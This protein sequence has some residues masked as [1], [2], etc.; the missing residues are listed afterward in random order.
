MSRLIRPKE[1]KDFKPI[2][3]GSY[4]AICYMIV[5]CGIISQSYKENPKMED[6]M[7]FYWEILNDDLRI[8]VGGQ[9]KRSMVYQD[10]TKSVYENSNMYKHMKP[11]LG[12][13]LLDESTGAFDPFVLIGSACILNVVENTSKKTGK[14][15]NKVASILALPK[16]IDPG[17]PENPLVLYEVGESPEEALELLPERMRKIIRDG[18]TGDDTAAN[19]VAVSFDPATGEV[20]ATPD[21]PAAPATPSAPTG[22]PAQAAQA[23]P[24]APTAAPTAAKPAE[25]EDDL[26]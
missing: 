13:E 9:L 2:P 24:A 20:T 15:Y 3:P 4:Q 22:P 25:P 1:K 11:W 21:P 6:T 5:D 17:E 16:G 18:K 12:R 26:P 14:K 8:D 19:S 7:F 23:M 10:Y